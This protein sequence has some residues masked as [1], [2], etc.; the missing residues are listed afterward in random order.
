MGPVSAALGWQVWVL[1]KGD[2]G[3]GSKLSFH[4]L[5]HHFPA[6]QGCR[7]R[8][9]G[10]PG[11]TRSCPGARLTEWVIFDFSVHNFYF[12]YSGKLQLTHLCRLVR[13]CWPGRPHDVPGRATGWSPRSFDGCARS[14]EL[15]PG[16][17]RRARA[18]RN[19]KLQILDFGLLKL[20]N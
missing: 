14:G 16:R 4:A 1:V 3:G 7:T 13:T 11:V 19:S 18:L 10:L 20:A 8:S 12:A 6:P 17:G 9:G 5:T 15:F 2:C